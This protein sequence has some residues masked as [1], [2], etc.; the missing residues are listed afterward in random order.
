MIELKDIKKSYYI[1]KKA[2][3][4]L[5][6]ISLGLGESGFIS[7]LGPSGCGKTTLLN[8]IGGLDK[9]DEG[10]LLIDG[11]TTKEFTDRNWDSYRNEQ[12][13]FVFQN[14]NLIPHQSV[15]L[16]VELSLTLNGIGHKERKERALK[17]LSLVGLESEAHKKPN[18]LSGGQMQRVAIARAIVNNPKVVLADEPT[19]A[20]DTKTSVQVLDILKEI[21]K[22]RLVIMVTH[23]RELADKYSDRII[24]MVDGLITSDTKPFEC[25]KIENN[26]VLQGKKTSMSV[27]TA[28]MSSLK[29]LKTKKSRTILTSIAC[30]IGIIGVALVLAISNGFN[31]YVDKVEG[32]IASSVPITITPTQYSSYST[33]TEENLVEYPSDN[34]LVVYNS[35]SSKYVAHRNNYTQDYFNYINKTVDMGLTSSIMYRQDYFDLHLLTRDGYRA[36]EGEW[37]VREIDAYTGVSSGN[38]IVSSIS[39]LPSTVFHELYGVEESVSRNYDVIYGKYPTKMDEIVLVTDKYN[40]IHFSILAAL[41]IVGSDQTAEDFVGNAKISFSELI[42]DKEGD[43]KY[44]EYKCYRTSDFY[45]VAEHDVY[46]R[47]YDAWNITNV[48]M[49]LNK[50]LSFE[51][52]PITK[53]FEFYNRDSSKEIYEDDEKYNPIK[54]KIVGVLRPNSDNVLNLMPSSLAYLPELREELVADTH[55][56]ENGDTSKD[57][58]GATLARNSSEMFYLRRDLDSAGNPTANDG[59]EKLRNNTKEISEALKESSNVTLDQNTVQNLIGSCYTYHYCWVYRGTIPGYTNTVTGFLYLAKRVGADFKQAEITY[60]PDTP[61]STSD[62]N[63]LNFLQFWIEVL[64]TPEFYN[65]VGEPWSV[66]ISD[67]Y[68]YQDVTWGITDFLAYFNSYAVVSSISIFPM[69]VSTKAALRDYLSAY[70]KGKEDTKQIL[71]TDTLADLTD[72][73]ADLVNAITMVLVMFASVSLVVSS[74]MTGIITYVSVVERKKEIGIL[75]ACG[76]RKVDVGWLFEAECFVIGFVSGVLGVVITWV[77]TYPI[78]AIV[79]TLYPGYNLGSIADVSLIHSLIMVVAA[80]ILAL[81]SGF[82]PARIAAKK[83]PVIALRSE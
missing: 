49:S 56:D 16:N 52:E 4:A 46:T 7:I 23:N 53:T 29:S 24:E 77:V 67:E 68:E 62:D 3:P 41:G 54:L 42:Y 2:Y 58:P 71:F 9:Y 70:N 48:T 37:A 1:D 5:K 74:I 65:S 72:S 36:P 26:G 60:L 73:I 83:N 50:G 44:K 43:T 17:A 8:I 34:N 10:D 64:T 55:L 69:G 51:A 13:G 47:T 78:N 21:S 39:G 66:R 75:R 59:L 32:S 40:R 14:Y 45:N 11:K 76:A 18:Q 15:L 30:S 25:P 81:I 20:L 31:G 61:T 35:K 82:I 33:K 63:Y 6:G 22:E 28:F 38:S 19:G 27:G 79:N 80:T 57:G 12:I